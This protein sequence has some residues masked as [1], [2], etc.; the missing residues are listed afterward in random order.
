M[1]DGRNAELCV[2]CV[3]PLTLLNYLSVISLSL[4]PSSSLRLSSSSVAGLAGIQEWLSVAKPNR[5]SQIHNTPSALSQARGEKLLIFQRT[6]HYHSGQNAAGIN[7]E[8]LGCHA[9]HLQNIH[10][11]PPLEKTLYQ[12]P[13]SYQAIMPITAEKLKSVHT[14]FFTNIVA[15]SFKVQPPNHKYIFRSSYLECYLSIKVV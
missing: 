8:A 4:F 12:R 9:R 6:L 3:C 15:S 11:F 14:I 2:F 13:R 7:A 1:T 5:R 10:T